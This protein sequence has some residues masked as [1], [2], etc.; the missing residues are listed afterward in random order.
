MQLKRN[1]QENIVMGVG[2]SMEA[3]I[4]GQLDDDDVSD[5]DAIKVS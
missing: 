4:M 1:F 5:L 2:M 3:L